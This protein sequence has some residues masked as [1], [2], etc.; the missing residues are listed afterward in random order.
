MEEIV[1]STREVSAA[2]LRQAEAWIGSGE[3][4]ILIGSQWQPAQSGDHFTTFN[5]ATGKPLATIAAGGAADIDAAV[6]SARTAFDEHWARFDPYS[7]EVLLHR[8]AD[9][10][11]RI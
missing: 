11:E 9:V 2:A 4:R 8:V 1:D 7:R 6:L 3:K 10:L 5:P